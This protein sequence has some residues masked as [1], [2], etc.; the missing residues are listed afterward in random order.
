MTRFYNFVPF[1]K[2][3]DDKNELNRAF[4]QEQHARALQEQQNERQ[5]EMQQSL[6]LEASK[7]TGKA[8][9]AFDKLEAADEN[10]RTVREAADKLKTELY[11]T[12]L[13]LDRLKN[14][15]KDDQ[16]LHT[17]ENEDLTTRIEDLKHDI[18][19]IG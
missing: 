10:M 14:R 8:V 15:T 13:E 18:V 5:I 9:D 17:T 3:E 7:H 2:L 19:S 6:N 1:L 4:T 16:R 12:K 11:G